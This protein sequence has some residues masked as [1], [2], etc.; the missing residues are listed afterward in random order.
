MFF[1]GYWALSNNQVFFGTPMERTH[2][3]RP[4]DPKHHLIDHGHYLNHTHWMFIIIF[5]FFIKKIII[6]T[7]A[8]CV[9]MCKTWCC[10][11]EEAEQ[12]LEEADMEE[13]IG[14]YWDSLTGDDQKIW[15]T[16]EV[17]SK[18]MYGIKS[19]DD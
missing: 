4:A 18:H 1:L 6:D 3:N 12:V 15:Y 10:E 17:Y 5:S 14:F 11:P 13:E 19:V 16:S 9:T 2:N 8:G 7:I